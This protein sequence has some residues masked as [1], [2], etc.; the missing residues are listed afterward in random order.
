MV[1]NHAIKIIEP[2][3]AELQPLVNIFTCNQIKELHHST[4]GFD[5]KSNFAP[6]N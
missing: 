1:K 4:A 2:D 3:L 5:F 6:T